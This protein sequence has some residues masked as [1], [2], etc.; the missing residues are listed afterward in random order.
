[1]SI[2]KTSNQM[3]QSLAADPQAMASLSGRIASDPK[4]AVHEVSQQFEAM[5][6]NTL[7]KGMRETHF[8]DDDQSSEMQTYR[9]LLDQQLVQSLTSGSG[10]GLS[11]MLEQQISKLAHITDDG[12]QALPSTQVQGSMPTLSPRMLRAFQE[13][14]G[15][16][17]AHLSAPS[18]AAEASAA[19]SAASSSTVSGGEDGV[20][21]G[22]ARSFVRSLLPHAANA[23][24]QLGVAPEVLVAHA[25]LESGWGKRAIR[26]ADGSDS[27][28][29]F[30]I[31]AGASWHGASTNVMTTEYVNGVAQKK[32]DSFRAYGSYKEA[33]ADYANLLSSSSRY[34]NAMNQGRNVQ[35][36]AQGL[37]SGGYAT[38]PRYAHKLIDVMSSLAQ[39]SA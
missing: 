4:G 6:M 26:N 12:S 33:F 32:V 19:A 22:N 27:H 29:L 15:K 13:M 21:S 5:F 2:Y 16:T 7:L 24:A 1:M 34:R 11:K 17:A 25:A 9:G 23:G 8:S 36:F 10:M 39:F 38:D 35:G 28:N 31:K 3:T 20:T 37:Q 18:A 30:G 14:Q